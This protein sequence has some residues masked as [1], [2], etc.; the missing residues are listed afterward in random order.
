MDI[1]RKLIPLQ[2][3][4]QKKNSYLDYISDAVLKCRIVHKEDGSREHQV[5]RANNQIETITNVKIEDLLYRDFSEVFPKINSSLFDWNKIIIDA[6]M[7]NNHTVI[8]QYFDAFE[9]FLKLNIFNYENE[10]E[11]FYITIADLTNQKEYKRQILERDR[12]I[13]HLEADVRSKASIDILTKLYN[14]QYMVESIENSIENYK[15][16]D[17][18]FCIL[19]VD[20]DEFRKI[21]KLYGIKTGDAVLQDIAIILSSVARKIDVVGKYGNDKYIL[22]F[23]NL[24]IEIAK[25][26]V[27]K[28]KQD[29]NKYGMKLK[30]I[31]LSLSGALLEYS[32]ETIEEFLMKAELMLDKAKSMGKGNI[33][34]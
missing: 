6:A 34:S 3:G 30:E 13:K 25:I 17:V 29:I 28:L 14:F 19:L 23:N 8:E 18:S 15:G 5:I 31:K 32:G 7:T 1:N 21:N 10:N 11:T 16:D 4:K 27:E 24:E 26:L 9:K 12:Q 20:V 22:I 2:F 33:I